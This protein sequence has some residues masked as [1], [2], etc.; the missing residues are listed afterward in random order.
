GRLDDN[1]IPYRTRLG[2]HTRTDS[3][4]IASDFPDY[5]PWHSVRNFIPDQDGFC[6]ICGKDIQNSGFWCSDSCREKFLDEI[7]THHVIRLMRKIRRLPICT[8]C[9]V[10]VTNDKWLIEQASLNNLPEVKNKRGHHLNYEEDETITV[11]ASCHASIHHSDKEEFEEYKP[12]DEKKDARKCKL[13]PCS[14]CDG[15]TRVPVEYKDETGICYKCRQKREREKSKS[16]KIRSRGY[17][18]YNAD[19]ACRDKFGM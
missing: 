17:P 5:L 8:C 14:D 19:I 12:E 11:C 3:S 10:Y 6:K 4:S 7:Q 16:K 15:K 2:F 9:G 1:E 13:I 18:R